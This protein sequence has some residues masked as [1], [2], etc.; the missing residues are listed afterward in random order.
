MKKVKIFG[1]GIPILAIVAIVM[2]AGM[3]SAALLSYY[4]K[5]TATANVE[6]SVVVDDQDYLNPIVERFDTVGGNTVVM[7][8]ILTNRSEISAT[9]NFETSCSAVDINDDWMKP[10]GVTVTYLKPLGY[11]YNTTIEVNDSGLF[12]DVTVEDIGDEVVWTF[13]FPVEEF[14]GDGNLNVALIIAL[15]GEDEGPA[16][17]IHN[18]DG[19][20]SSHDWGTWLVSPWGP[21]ID[22]G[23]FGWHSG[24]TNTPV[25]ELDWVEAT[26]NRNVPHGE[27]ILQIKIEKSKLGPA[28]H[29]A[30]NP[31]VGSGFFAVYDVDMEI[32]DISL[33]FDWGNPIVSTIFVDAIVSTNYIYAELMGATN[34]I[35]I[36]PGEER[37]FVIV[38]NFDIATKP[39][40]YTITTTVVPT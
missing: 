21:T 6:Q 19:T 16:F 7:P 26:G 22:D 13:D 8:H 24:D 14:T 10:D 38:Y 4:G 34:E 9:V 11:T 37:G 23:W 32:P 39:G 2:T 30:A 33:G 3:A 18:N 17:Q 1:R 12:L 20:D 15:D 35:T 5:I 27:G 25:T 29:W 36:P 28:F 40:I 31:T